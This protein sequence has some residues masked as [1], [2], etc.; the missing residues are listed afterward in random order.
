MYERKLNKFGDG[1]IISMAISRNHTKLLK[2]NITL[3]CNMEYICGIEAF[4]F[5]LIK[6]MDIKCKHL[7]LEL[8]WTKLKFL[9]IC[10]VY[11]VVSIL[12]L[13]FSYEFPN[14]SFRVS[15]TLLPLK[16][17][18]KHTATHRGTSIKYLSVKRII[19]Q[20]KGI[21]GKSCH[22]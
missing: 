15:G 19:L 4:H 6:I 2:P 21:L 20:C 11:D 18:W 9:K 1:F 22:D 5:F 14:E 17:H 10:V 7:K 3:F 12:I 13:L 8:N 16:Y